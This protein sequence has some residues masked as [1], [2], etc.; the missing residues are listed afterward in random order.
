MSMTVIV[1][2]FS[3]KF[4]VEIAKQE[5]LNLKKYIVK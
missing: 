3:S 2:L 4:L 1:I 5:Q